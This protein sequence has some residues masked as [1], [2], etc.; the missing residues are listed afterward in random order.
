PDPY[1]DADAGRTEANGDPVFR[2]LFKNSEF[3]KQFTNTLL[4]IRNWNFEYERCEKEIDRLTDIYSP[5]MENNRERWGTGDIWGGVN[6]MKNFLRKRPEYVLT[7]LEDNIDE[8]DINDR[9]NLT[10][11]NSAK[12]ADAVGVNTIVPDSSK[13][14]EGVYYKDYPITVTAKDIDGYTFDHWDVSG[15]TVSAVNEAEAVVTFT[16]SYA[17]INAVYAKD[18]GPGTEDNLDIGTYYVSEF[19]VPFAEKKNAGDSVGFEVQIND[20]GKGVRYGTLN[21]FAHTSPY[22]SGEQFGRLILSDSDSD[23]E[24]DSENNSVI[25]DNR[26]S[27]IRTSSEISVDGVIDDAW[28]DAD[29]VTLGRYQDLIS[30]NSGASDGGGNQHCSAKAKFLWDDKNLYV[31]VVTEDE[32]IVHNPNGYE[33]DSVEIFYDE[34]AANPADYTDDM[35]QFRLLHNGIKENGK[36][37]PDAYIIESDVKVYD[38]KDNNGYIAEFAVPFKEQKNAGDKVSLELQIADCISEADRRIGKLN[39]FADSS[40]FSN[41]SQFGLVTLCDNYEGRGFEADSKELYAVRSDEAI[42]ADGIIEDAWQKAVPVVIEKYTSK[43]V[44]GT[45]YEQS[46]AATARIMWDSDNMYV[47]VKVVDNDLKSNDSLTESDCVELFFDERVDEDTLKSED[48]STAFQYRISYDGTCESGKNYEDSGYSVKAAGSITEKEVPLPT[49][50]QT[51]S[52]TKGPAQTDE[53]FT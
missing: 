17:R 35:F 7:M 50:T 30:D 37:N 9:V 27:V 43:E 52:P 24:N 6:A 2:A 45:V 42:I 44:D 53:K 10:V 41:R 4:D 20:C 13:G 14:F 3:R 28:N 33:S 32:N 38:G 15:A 16:D 40:P 12:K 22:D 11:T 21:L 5:L 1:N 36:G 46:I 26:L 18:G 25:Q 23:G 31:L 34:D 48:Y 47:L 19:A 49:P 39:L 51:P 29:Y 8:L